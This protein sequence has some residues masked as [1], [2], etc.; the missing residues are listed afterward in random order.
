MSK[1][2]TVP[3]YNADIKM[4]FDRDEFIKHHEN[5]I[6]YVEL[7]E[8]RGII[9]HYF[10]KRGYMVIILGIFAD[11]VGVLVH[12][13]IHAVSRIYEVHG[14]KHDNNN[15]EPTAYLMQRLFYLCN[16]RLYEH[17]QKVNNG[18]K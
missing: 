17:Y 12:E 1:N 15:D 5:K 16:E 13:L 6:G 4:F 14:I 11:D 10:N 18:S 2:I 8:D 9:N 3:L 7:G